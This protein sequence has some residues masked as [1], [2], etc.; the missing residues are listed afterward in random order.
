MV[1]YFVNIV[2][3]LSPNNRKMAKFFLQLYLE[4]F[5]KLIL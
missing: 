4:Y 3:E 1:L 5:F 2:S